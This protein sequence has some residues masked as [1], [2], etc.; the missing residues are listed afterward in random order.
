MDAPLPHGECM[1]A[2]YVPKIAG[3]LFD[4]QM[5][6]ECVREETVD[7]DYNRL[8]YIDPEDLNILG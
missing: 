1:P 3:V 4:G 6:N 5:S 8:P 7:D 2:E